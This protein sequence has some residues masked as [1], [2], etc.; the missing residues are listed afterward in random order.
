MDLN[1]AELILGLKGNYTI[2]DVKKNFRTLALKYHPDKN[3]DEDASKKFQDIYEAYEFLNNSDWIKIEKEDRTF[4]NAYYNDDSIFKNNNIFEMFLKSFTTKG[5]TRIDPVILNNLL[6]LISKGC[7]KLSQKMF[8]MFDKPTVLKMFTYAL[9]LKDILGLTKEDISEM[10]YSLRS[11]DDDYEVYLL[12]PN[13]ENLLLDQIY[14]LKHEDKQLYIPL[15]H[16]ELVYDIC[17]QTVIVRCVPELP[18]NISIDEDNNLH[19]RIIKKFEE[20]KNEKGIDISEYKL[21][22]NKIEIDELF[23]KNEQ[24]Y[25]IKNKGIS[26]IDTNNIFNTSNRANIIFHIKIIDFV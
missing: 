6:H 26:E 4:N 22:I 24:T 20:L 9:Q 23:I 10:E 14:I 19:I 7:K 18:E 12:N 2:E 16:S 15:W 3:K 5:G 13:L 17:G 11:K 8:E 25:I 21:Q 1:K